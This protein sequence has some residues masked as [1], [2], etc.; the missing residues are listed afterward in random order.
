M[1]YNYKSDEA[2]Q[3]VVLNDI[4]ELLKDIEDEY[5]ILHRDEYLFVYAPSYIAKKIV[6][7]LLTDV[8]AFVH[9]ESYTDLLDK[10]DNNVLLT[11][12]N[13]GMLFVEDARWKDKQLKYT[14]GCSLAYVYDGFSK[15]DVDDLAERGDSIL[16][17]GFNEKDTEKKDITV[18]KD[19]SVVTTSK[20]VYKVNGKECDKETYEKALEKFT[21]KYMGNVQDMLLN[22]FEFFDEMRNWARLFN[23]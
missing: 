14:D 2:V 12:A 15:K 21:D 17:F 16:V 9:E 5:K 13:D 6:T 11:V 1:I 4:G 3:D 19:K 18:D 23:W 20:S 8:D 22:Y 10:E 7:R